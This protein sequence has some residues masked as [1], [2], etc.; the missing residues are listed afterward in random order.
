M[1]RGDTLGILN[2]VH[3]TWVMNIGYCAMGH[4]VG[5]SARL[6]VGGEA[7]NRAKQLWG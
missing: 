7:L 4:L 6:S 2:L 1:A 3:G 5:Y